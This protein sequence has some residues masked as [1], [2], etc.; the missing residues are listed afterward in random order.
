MSKIGSSGVGK[1][2]SQST[3]MSDSTVAGNVRDGSDK[4][5]NASMK[6]GSTGGAGKN[7]RSGFLAAAAGP[8]YAQV[9]AGT[10]GPGTG[11]GG[12]N[13]LPMSGATVLPGTMPKGVGK[14]RKGPSNGSH[15]GYL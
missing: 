8:G 6:G 15:K 12:K 14:G 2:S 11:S 13:G 4:A 10:A 1:A 9:S 3:G 7:S 5:H